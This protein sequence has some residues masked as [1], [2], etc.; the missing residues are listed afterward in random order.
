MTSFLKLFP[1]LLKWTYI[2]DDIEGI[3]Q[4]ISDGI[5]IIDASNYYG[6]FKYPLSS[7]RKYSFDLPKELNKL[8]ITYAIPRVKTSLRKFGC[9]IH[10]KNYGS[11]ILSMKTETNSKNLMWK[12]LSNE[13]KKLSLSR[14]DDNDIIIRDGIFHNACNVRLSIPDTSQISEIVRTSPYSSDELSIIVTSTED[15]I[16]PHYKN[17]FELI[18]KNE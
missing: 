10:L 2:P 12:R 16:N 14:Y 3:I 17:K 4:K 18:S 8:I 13:S 6:L 9:G 1:F 11:C 7:F 5:E 15:I